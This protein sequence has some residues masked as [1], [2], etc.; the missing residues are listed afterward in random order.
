MGNY[1]DRLD[2]ENALPKVI[3]YNNNPTDNY[4]FASM[5]GNFQDGSTPGKMQFGAA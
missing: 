4:L 5:V 3:L 2:Q 1:L